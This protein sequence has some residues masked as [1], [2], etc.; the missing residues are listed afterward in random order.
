VL[1]GKG[2]PDTKGE[3]GPYSRTDLCHYTS[4]RSK[5]A[6]DW[7]HIGLQFHSVQKADLERVGNA[8]G[9]KGIAAR[10]LSGDF[11]LTLVLTSNE[12]T[13]AH[14]YCGDDTAIPLDAVKLK[15][16]REVLPRVEFIKSDLVISNQVPLATLLAAYG[17]GTGNAAFDYVTVQ[18]IANELHSLV[19]PESKPTLPPRSPPL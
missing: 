12:D 14:L 19:L 5:N 11:L 7:P 2:I 10:S 6:E 13:C 3:P 16:V 15:A 8:I 17:Q 4:P 9:D 1:T 18:R